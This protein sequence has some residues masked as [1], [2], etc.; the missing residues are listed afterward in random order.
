MDDATTI[1]RSAALDRLIDDAGLAGRAPARA[2]RSVEL[3][4]GASPLS[5]A[6]GTGRSLEQRPDGSCSMPRRLEEAPPPF[7]SL[8]ATTRRSSP[9]PGTL[10]AGR[11]VRIPRPLYAN[12]QLLAGDNLALA[13]QLVEELRDGGPVVFD[14]YHHGYGG[15]SPLGRGLD[16]RA[17][18]FATLQSLAA[19]GIYA[20]ARGRRFGP[21]R[22]VPDP[23]R[24]SSL[25]F[26]RSMA[27]LYRRAR[28][29]RHAIGAEIE[30]LARLAR[31]RPGGPDGEEVPAIARALA[32]GDPG[33]E[34]RVLGALRAAEPLASQVPRERCSIGSSIWRSWRRR[35]WVG[36]TG[37]GEASSALRQG[38]GSVVKGQDQAVRDL[39][40]ALFAGGHVLLEGPP[41][42]G[43]TLLVK[44]LAR[45]V[46]AEF[47]RIQFTPDL[48]PA[49]VTGTTV[50]R[51]QTAELHFVP[52][53]IFTQILLADEI[54]RTP[55]K[56]QA[57]LLEAMQ[58]RQVTID[59]RTRPLPEPFF[60]AATQ[61]PVSTKGPTC[62]P[63]R[64]STGSS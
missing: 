64:S 9:D 58:E 20:A 33:V 15:L 27:S 51:P 22:I 50:F 29:W 52:G 34:A 19:A 16:G 2:A 35:F 32:S 1:E 62:F 39:V 60:V 13:L 46:R 26:V 30:R 3:R 36:P 12:D 24:R 55:P 59:G 8:S 23:P 28:G 44:T 31:G 40:I 5:A 21:P 43:K 61:N 53:P 17:L 57:A 47:Q 41:G 18:V 10:A 11:A 25:E 54:N 63:R 6:A 48:M 45:L 37:L 56:T 42:L 38:L 4:P 14:E 7:P 49:D